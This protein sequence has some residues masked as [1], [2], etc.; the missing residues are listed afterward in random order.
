MR[1]GLWD[2]LLL[3]V[4]SLMATTI[5]YIHNARLKALML[6]LPIPFSIANLSLGLEV[7]ATNVLGLLVLYLFTQGVRILH[8]VAGVNIIAAIILPAVAYCLAGCGLAAAAPKTETMFWATSAA[9]LL[10]GVGIHFM[11]EDVDEPG[12]RSSLPVWQ[13]LMAV[14]VVIGILVMIKARLQ[15]FM[16]VFPMVG[17]IAAYETRHSLAT[18]CRK[19]GELMFIMLP[20]MAVMRIGQRRFGF[21]IGQSLLFGWIALLACL[22]PLALDAWRKSRRHEKKF[23]VV[24]FRS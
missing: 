14:M 10:I 23:Q 6:M 9:V 16:T 18:T 3:V 11:F 1:I 20:M 15:G 17:V 2:V 7:D 4:V 8:S 19:V 13:K 21:S 22:F 5:A 12:H 24:R